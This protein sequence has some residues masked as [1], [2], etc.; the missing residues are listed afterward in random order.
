[1][2]F[3]VI[4]KNDPMYSRYMIKTF[5]ATL[6]DCLFFRLPTV[7]QKARDSIPDYDIV[8]FLACAFER[9]PPDDRV[10]VL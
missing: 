8:G 10:N 7:V 9:P 5:G 1:M 2:T 6:A 4:D 3:S